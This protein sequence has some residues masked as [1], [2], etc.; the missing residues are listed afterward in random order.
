MVMTAVRYHYL[1]DD[2]DTT[3]DDDDDDAVIDRIMN[4]N[5]R[6]LFAVS[7]VCRSILYA[8]R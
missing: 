8:S 2:C 4:V 3:V 5:L 6:A 7:Q 1:D